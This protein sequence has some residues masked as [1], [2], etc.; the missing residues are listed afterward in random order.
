MIIKKFVGKTQ[1]DAVEAAK[2]ELGDGVV[3]MNVKT[4]KR[5]GLMAL[6]RPKMTEVTVAL[7]EEKDTKTFSRRD[8]NPGTA[9]STLLQGGRTTSG[10]G[11]LRAED[12]ALEDRA[13]IEKK[14]D[15]L[16]NLL[17]SRFQQSESERRDLLAEEEELDAEESGEEEEIEEKEEVTEQQRFMKLLYNTMLESEVD[18][19]YAN[20]IVDEVDVS[21]QSNLPFDYILG[22]VYQKM[23]LK[24]G[25]AEGITTVEGHPKIVVFM[26]PTG[27]GK[28]TTI[29]KIASNYVVEEKRQVALLTADTY[30][31]AAVDQLRTYANI[32]EVPFRVIYSEDEIK[33]A[34]NEFENYDYIFVD[35]A[36]HS[37][38]NEEQLE[39]MKRLVN[40][41]QETGDSQVF[42][43]LSATTKYRDLLKIVSRYN[44]IADYQLIFTKLDETDV[45]GNLLN[46]KLYTEKPIAFV[47]YGQNVPNDIEL[48]NPQKT[49]KQILSKKQERNEAQEG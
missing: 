31:I 25:R 36:G 14:L 30:R 47:T 17:V 20:Q 33:E 4:V 9:Q 41:V 7:E 10:I 28:T 21:G 26:G 8:T 13:S 49:V 22:N 5:K 2:K 34:I 6:F 35:T 38:Q 45:E 46:L 29:A 48:F 18:E 39:H 23:I 32:L 19:K 42:L 16:Q 12:S 15:N 40:V 1:E 27:V 24:F 37:H 44:Q 3:I 11:S 43:V